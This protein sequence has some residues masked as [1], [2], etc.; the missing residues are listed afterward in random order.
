MEDSGPGIPKH[1]REALFSKFQQSLDLLSQ[2]TGVGLCLCKQ[3]ISVMGAD[4]WLDEE[5][6]SGVTGCPG[7]CFVVDLRTLPKK[8]SLDDD[9]E[10][11]TL[12]S[13]GTEEDI[14][15][16]IE[17]EGQNSN[18]D[19]LQASDNP[20][21]MNGNSVTPAAEVRLPD[22]LSVLFVD[23]EMI[24]RKLFGRSIKRVCPDWR[25]QEASSGETAIRLVD[26]E[27]FDMIFMD[28][29]MASTEKQLLGTEATRELRSRGVKA[30]ICGLS[31]N[32]NVKSSFLS[33]GADGFIVK[34][35]P[36]D[37][38]ELEKILVRLLYGSLEENF[39]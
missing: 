32:D 10:A 35:A 6:D 28:Q 20:S 30:K 18:I 19:S 22:E 31:A 5:F 21:I 8:V 14:S 11:C 15:T 24:Q 1:K 38:A 23:D 34:P 36:C 27:T 12:K 7:A 4:L 26:T 33:A 9:T 25:V 2:G 16:C 29:Y 17:S 37:K 3:L 13:E 39:Q